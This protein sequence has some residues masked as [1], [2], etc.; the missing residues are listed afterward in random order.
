MTVQQHFIHKNCQPSPQFTMDIGNRHKPVL[1]LEH[2]C[3]T[4]TT[5]LVTGKGQKGGK[6]VALY[7]KKQEP[8]HVMCEK[9]YPT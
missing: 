4:N 5:F 1:N 7:C 2:C 6:A 9:L 8:N 3:Q